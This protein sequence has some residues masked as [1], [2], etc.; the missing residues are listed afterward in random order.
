MKPKNFAVT[1]DRPRFDKLVKHIDAE[2]L[3]NRAFM[4]K[5]VDELPVNLPSKG[6]GK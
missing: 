5:L 2:R 6:K 4:E 3:T 1:L